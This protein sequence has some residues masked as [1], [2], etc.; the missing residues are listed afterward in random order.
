[1]P[2]TLARAFNMI[3]NRFGKMIN[4]MYKD[5]QA[6][7]GL[8]HGLVN[9]FWGVFD[10]ISAVAKAVG[11][12]GNELKLVGIIIA[13]VFGPWMVA[14]V[15]AMAA[16]T[17]LW[18][19]PFALAIA[20]IAAVALAI[21]DLYAFVEGRPS[22]FADF[23]SG[24]KWLQDIVNDIIRIKGLMSART[25]ETAAAANESRDVGASGKLAKDAAQHDSVAAAIIKSL[26]GAGVA[27][28]ESYFPS[29]EQFKRPEGSASTTERALW[30]VLAMFFSEPEGGVNSAAA[31]LAPYRFLVDLF[32]GGPNRGVDAMSLTPKAVTDNR[33]V[34]VNINNPAGGNAANVGYL[35]QAAGVIFWPTFGL[36]TGTGNTQ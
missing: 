5:T 15:L 16:A 14:R 32:G 1:M 27:G 9:T 34:E 19:A 10:A 11:G 28:V 13:S 21:D 3:E 20:V 33:K 30:N 17:W 31:G 6:F 22:L 4:D 35:E 36:L 23:V 29:G 12:Y 26:W 25:A 7:N 18:L 2:L 24:H 8:A